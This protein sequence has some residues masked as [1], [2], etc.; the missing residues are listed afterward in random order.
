MT[1]TKDSD[2]GTSST[3]RYL[4]LLSGTSK[5]YGLLWLQTKQDRFSLVLGVDKDGT[6]N[7]R[8]VKERGG[9]KGGSL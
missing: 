2:L 3:G 6:E 5:P 4:S 7:L 1:S 8:N 9:T